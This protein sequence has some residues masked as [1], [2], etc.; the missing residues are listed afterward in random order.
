MNI[1]EKQHRLEQKLARKNAKFLVWREKKIQKIHQKIKN[2]QA[3]INANDNP[4]LKHIAGNKI[5][6]LNY[7]LEQLTKRERLTEEDTFNFKFKRWFFGVG[8][9]FSRISWP[10]KG[11]V[12]R[13]FVIIIIIVFAIALIYFGID[14]LIIP[15][16]KTDPATTTEQTTALIF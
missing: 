1:L 4:K 9:E 13:D 11:S 2:Y 12:L 16:I 14:A 3:I 5:H 7:H 15:L 8:K 6:T 10:K